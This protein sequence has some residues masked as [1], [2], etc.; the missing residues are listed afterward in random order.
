MYKYVIWQLNDT[1]ETKDLKTKSLREIKAPDRSNYHSVFEAEKKAPVALSKLCE[2]FCS[3]GNILSVSAVITVVEEDTESTWWQAME[4]VVFYK[5]TEEFKL[6][7][8]ASEEAISYTD[9]RLFLEAYLAAASY[10]YINNWIAIEDYHLPARD[11]IE[12][13]SAEFSPVVYAD[14][15]GSEGIYIEVE[16]SGRFSSGGEFGVRHIGTVKTLK[17]SVEDLITAGACCGALTAMIGRIAN[18]NYDSFQR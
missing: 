11:T 5:D 4:P 6:C 8:W 14:Y 9:A 17:D 16:I 7:H 13:T 2:Q 18:L 12:F 3:A 1:P 10:G 15:G